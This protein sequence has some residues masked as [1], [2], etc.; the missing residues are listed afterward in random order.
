[1]DNTLANET[2][3]SDVSF[4]ASNLPMNDSILIVEEVKRIK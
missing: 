2:M 1:M 3:L 4:P